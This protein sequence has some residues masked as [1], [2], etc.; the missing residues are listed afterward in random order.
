MW[1]DQ[2]KTVELLAGAR[3]GDHDAVNRLMDRHRD[4][5]HRMVRCRLNQGVARRV[6]ASDIVQDALLTASRRLAEYLQS[7]KIPFHAW[8]R[9]IAR[10]RLA[11]VYRRELADKRNVGREQGTP[12]VGRSSLNPLAQASDHQLTPAAALLRKEFAERFNAAVDQLEDDD[13]E[14]ILMRHSEQLSNSQAAEVLGLSEPA[15]GMRYLRALRK[16]KSVLGDTQSAV[17]G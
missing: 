2:E 12:A 3:E 7:P 1:P 13:R 8:V 4:S 17:M 11:D 9:Q 15:A 14:I 10:D 5:L 16:L 6:D